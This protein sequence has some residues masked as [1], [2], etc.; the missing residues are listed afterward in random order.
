MPSDRQEWTRGPWIPGWSAERPSQPQHERQA[1]AQDQPQDGPHQRVPRGPYWAGEQPPPP[2][3][4]GQGPAQDNNTRA[5][6]RQWTAQESRDRGP[7]GGYSRENAPGDWRSYG[8]PPEGA[9]Q[10]PRGWWSYASRDWVLG[11]PDGAEETRGQR[12]GQ[13]SFDRGRQDEQGRQEPE[14]DRQRH[15]WCSHWGGVLVGAGVYGFYQ[16]VQSYTPSGWV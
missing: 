11:P 5:W 8:A 1:P 7:L 16:V 13:G 6:Q 4:H 15:G 10:A 12:R 14:G 3:Q 9:P 2:Q